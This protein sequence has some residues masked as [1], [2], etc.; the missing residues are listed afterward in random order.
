MAARSI[1]RISLSLYFSLARSVTVT[2]SNLPFLG[3]EVSFPP[4]Q[5]ISLLVKATYPSHEPHDGPII[6][7]HRCGCSGSRLA[8][9]KP[10]T[11]AFDEDMCV[12]S[13]GMM[14][15]GQGGRRM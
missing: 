11:M 9:P 12:T 15:G 10:L 1:P 6:S 8:K 14:A 7:L 5:R 13:I 2:H 3:R 4:H